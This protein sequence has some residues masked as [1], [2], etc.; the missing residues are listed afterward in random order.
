[1]A[2]ALAAMV[3]LSGAP[4]GMQRAEAGW[5]GWDD[6]IEVVSGT[7]IASFQRTQLLE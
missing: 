1:M 2:A 5:D 3:M 7:L 6:V 4:C